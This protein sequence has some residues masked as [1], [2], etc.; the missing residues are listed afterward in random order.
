ML[1]KEPGK[2]I[3]KRMDIPLKDKKN[4]EPIAPPANVK[5]DAGEGSGVSSPMDKA[6]DN[7]DA[8]NVNRGGNR[9][10]EKEEMQQTTVMISLKNLTLMD[11]Y[12]E[13]HGSSRSW[14]INKALTLFFEQERA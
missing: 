11:E 7:I 10:T 13:D 4:V 1:N 2:P 9:K 6:I 8:K 3:K 14:V 12:H 5:N